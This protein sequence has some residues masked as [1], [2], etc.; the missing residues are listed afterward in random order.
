MGPRKSD[1]LGGDEL[2]GGDFIKE[3][4]ILDQ[5]GQ[6]NCDELNNF[7]KGLFQRA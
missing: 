3:H 2:R 1:E 6:T 4:V 5:M 7:F